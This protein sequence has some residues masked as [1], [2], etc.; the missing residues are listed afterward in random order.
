MYDALNRRQ[1]NAGAFKFIRVVQ[2]LKHAK[3]FTY[4]LH[5][6]AHSVVPYE[7][8]QFISVSLGASDFDLGLDARAC[9]FNGIGDKIDERKL[10]H[11]TISVKIG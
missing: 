10:Q 8:Y 3:Q 1:S 7:Y 2:S 4:V 6:K 9:E 11:R 5:I